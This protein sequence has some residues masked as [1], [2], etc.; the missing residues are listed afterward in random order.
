[1]A[2]GVAAIFHNC[3]HF[4]LYGNRT[5]ARRAARGADEKKP[6]KRTFRVFLYC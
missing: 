3:G 2:K 4:L 6:G 5:A 1:M